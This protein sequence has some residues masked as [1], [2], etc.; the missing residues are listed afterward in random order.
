MIK[1]LCPLLFTLLVLRSPLAWYL[2]PTT[3]VIVMLVLSSILYSPLLGPCYSRPLMFLDR[4]SWPLIILTLWVFVLSRLARQHLWVNLQRPFLFLV[5][6]LILLLTLFLCFTST[7][8]L[9]FYFF[10]ET[11]LVPTLLLIIIWGYQ[12]ERLQAGTYLI[13]YTITASLPLL[14]ALLVLISFNGHLRISLHLSSLPVSLSSSFIWAV[15]LSIAFLVKLPLY[16][17]H[18]W[19]PKAHVEAPVAGSMILAGI[20]LKL[21]VYGLLRIYGSFPQLLNRLFFVIVP[22]RLLGAVIT[23]LVCLRQTDFKALIAYSSVGHIGLLAGGLFSGFRWGWQGALAISV[24][25]GLCSSGL[26]ALA[27][28]LYLTASTRRLFLI[29]G[30]QAYFPSI[31]IWWFLFSIRNIAAPPSINLLAEILLISSTLAST[32]IA[33]VP[34]GLLRF[35]AA[36]YSLFLYTSLHHGSPRKQINPLIHYL[37]AN[38]TILFLHLAPLIALILFPILSTAW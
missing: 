13:L 17:T 36:A 8:F 6:S 26:F 21:G 34:L 4:L 37:P 23:S 22:L 14:I 5:L 33:A 16:S 19:L 25:H 20:L 12:P 15:L 27:N 35:L 30:L 2:L 32:Y 7:N 3:L 18:L 9:L 29:K 38:Y 28:I 1:F 31:T 11:S 24:A 10:F